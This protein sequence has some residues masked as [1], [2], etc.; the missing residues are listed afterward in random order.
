MR[1]SRTS[2][3]AAIAARI[4][5]P[6]SPSDTG[7]SLQL[8]RRLVGEAVALLLALDREADQFVQEARQGEAARLPELGIHGNGGEAGQGV[9][10]V[11]ENAVGAALEK[12]IHARHA[13][14]P[15][16]AEGRDSESPDFF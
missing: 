16:G 9:Q 10:L 7:V 4:E 6:A 15:R 12:E 13:G 11:D 1:A 5:R 2:T 3:S 8:G 14:D